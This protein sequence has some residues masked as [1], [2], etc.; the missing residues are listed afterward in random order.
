MNTSTPVS[1]V[2]PA[3]PVFLSPST[4][5]QAIPSLKSTVKMDVAANDDER[6]RR[7]RRRS[8]VTDLQLSGIDSPLVS[9]AQRGTPQSF[10][11]KL[12]NNQISEHYS[13]CIKLC[14]EN[15]ITTKNAFGLHLIDYMA[16]LLKEKESELTSFK[17]AAGTLDASTKIYAV[18][19][20]AV[21]TDVFKILGGLGK[22]PEEP[23][24]E[25]HPG[26][27][28]AD[29]ERGSQKQQKKKHSYKTIE[30]N[31]S[32]ITYCL[33][34]MKCETDPM[35]QKAASLF[36]ESSTV[37]VFMVNLQT[38]GH[39]AQLL[40]D[41]DAKLI[42]TDSAPE[43]PPVSH[44]EIPDLQVLQQ[45]LENK[46]ICPSFED[47][48]FTNWDSEAHDQAVTS[49]LEKF[50]KSNHLFD[51]NAE[52]EFDDNQQ[53]VCPSVVDDFDGDVCDDAGDDQQELSMMN[54]DKESNDVIPL[55]DVDFSSLCVQLSNHPGEYSYFSPRIMRM[56]AGPNHWHFK[57]RHKGVEILDKNRKKK[58]K[59]AFEIDFEEK[60]KFENHFRETRAATT[61]A[62]ATLDRRNGKLTTLPTDFHYDPDTITC[63]F[64]KPSIKIKPNV[65]GN[66]SDQDEKIGEYDYNNPNDT[67]NFCPRAEMDS[68]DEH[69]GFV[70][71]N[72]SFEFTANV[73]MEQEENILE[74]DR[75][76]SDI[77]TYGGENL[78]AEPQKV[79][80]ILL[81]Y[82]KTAKM[83]DVKRLK[84]NMWA[85]LTGNAAVSD[86]KDKET[87]EP[88]V[89]V[90]GQQSLTAITTEL[91]KRLPNTLAKN[92]SVPMAFACLLHLANEKNLEI[93]GKED[94]SDVFIKQGI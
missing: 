55:T 12:S 85:L 52:S 69:D 20:D 63:L 32:N 79:N 87:E 66:V 58:P 33:N 41:S 25:V 30:Q 28:E 4:K 14:S 42:Q 10:E 75:K 83:M 39:S 46:T 59:K 19:V 76:W 94:L 15:K 18:R 6:E 45:S 11:A 9:P 74:Q 91:F 92:L 17:M 71:A 81:N 67:S 65:K 13:T 2:S 26:S 35:F 24:A 50:K 90:K 27:S 1:C 36:D 80:K 68:D 3:G 21:H 38:Y 64:L 53:D 22:N 47:F 8:K 48:Q 88:K 54:H 5:R 56:W 78:V 34:D 43:L 73:A 89:T 57:T 60:I 7:E 82:S 77:T 40:F 49:I 44:V 37:G 84:Q 23:G 51:V 31:L 86:G 93:K 62:K 72:D 16:D 61:I 29:H 70:G